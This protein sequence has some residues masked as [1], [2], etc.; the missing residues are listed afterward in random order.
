MTDAPK[1]PELYIAVQECSSGNERVGDVWLETQT[2]SPAT[3]LADV[4]EWTRSL[5]GPNGRLFLTKER[6]P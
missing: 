3:T 2:F 4:W 6:R 5:V 1:K